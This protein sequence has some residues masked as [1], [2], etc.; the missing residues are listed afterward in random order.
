MDLIA[1]SEGG[2]PK[3]D[4]NGDQPLAAQIHQFYRQQ[5]RDGHIPEGQQLPTCLELGRSLGVAAQTINRAFDLLAAERL[6]HR[7]RKVGTVVGPP[8]TTVPLPITEKGTAYRPF[9]MPICMVVRKVEAEDDY[10]I[11]LRSDY[12][13]GLM[14]GFGAWKCRFEIAY[15]QPEQPDLDLVRTLVETSQIRGLINQD[16]NQNVTDYLIKKNFPMV[17]PNL[18]LSA[19][20]V[21]SVIA[22]HVRGY[23][24]AWRYAHD[25]G[26]RCAA[27]F[28][29]DDKN[30]VTRR[31]ECA[32][33]RELAGTACGLER[34]VKAP[35]QAEPASIWQSLVAGLGNFGKNKGW[36]TLFFAQ[37]DWIATR[38]ICALQANGVC[39]P[40][41]VSVIGFDDAIVAR[42]FHPALTT[43]CKPRFK[44]ALAASQL[45]LDVLAK[46]SGSRGRLQVFPCA[47]VQRET[48]A[49]PPP[50]NS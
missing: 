36:P 44:M 17:M 11:S 49:P 5:I 16:L 27:F 32:A 26:H 4:F 38:L 46:R 30:F 41:D 21:A 37:N 34:H 9:T 40:R 39:V 10:G 8:P 3:L 47:F 6:V 23:G 35:D 22:D 12:V 1:S 13:N 25:I 50:A 31:R 19:Q 7:R 20:G 28:G 29:Y 24:E 15:L 33:G 2:L 18:D 43:I 42:Q 14:E 45:L 48:S